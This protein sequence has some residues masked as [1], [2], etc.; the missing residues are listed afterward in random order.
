MWDSLFVCVS[1][2]LPPG[3]VG[4]SGIS[5]C[6]TTQLAIKQYT[7]MKHLK[8]SCQK[9]KLLPSRCMTNYM[10]TCSFLHAPFIKVVGKFFT[11]V[12]GK[13]LIY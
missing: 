1:V 6:T 3:S 9:H 7:P 2:H 12:F 5:N 11:E 4:W 10:K 8:I 13:K